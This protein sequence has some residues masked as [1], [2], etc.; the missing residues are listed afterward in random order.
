MRPFLVILLAVLGVGACGPQAPPVLLGPERDRVALTDTEVDAIATILRLEDHRTFE[1]DTF[2]RLA[3]A[4]SPEVRRRA[5]TAAG[6]IGDVAAAPFLTGVLARDPH[7]AVRAD[8]AFALGLLGDTSATVL[9][10]LRQAAPRDWTP[11]RAEEATV[12]V[13]IVGALGRLGTDAARAEVVDVLRRVQRAD[14]PI[15][16]R[17]AAE[18]LLAVWKFSAGAGRTA[19]ALRFVD[20]H[21]PELRWRAALA[22]VRLGDSE[23]TPRLLPLLGDSDPRVRALAARGL[24]APVAD[25]AAIAQP[26]IEALVASLSDP[27]PHVRVNAVRALATF[28][29]RASRDAILD[30]A[31]DADPNVAIAA[32]AALATLG[33]AAGPDLA[34]IVANDALPVAVRAAALAS[35]AT[36]DPD[37]AAPIVTAWARAAHEQRYAAARSLVTLGWPGAREVLESL[38]ADPDRRVAVAATE[39]AAALAAGTDLPATDA[40]Q[41]RDLLLRLARADDHR[42]RT[43]ALRGVAPLLRA[44]DLAPVLAAYERASADPAARAT[45]IAAVRALGGMEATQPGPAA[46][47][48]AR[49]QPHPDRWIRR[50]VADSLGDRWG[51]PPLAAASD[52]PWFYRDIVHRYVVPALGSGRRPEATVRTPHGDIR[53]ELLPEEAPLTVHNFVTLAGEGYYDDGVWHRVVPNFVLQDGAP[54]GDPTGGPGWTIRDEFNRVR[55]GRGIMGMALSGPDTGGSQWFIT[56]S[57]QPHLDGGY[58]VFGRVVAGERAMDRVVQGDAVVTVRVRH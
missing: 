44:G 36:L 23:A 28:G 14:D 1:P 30:R 22:L 50:A 46:A 55:Y 40:A 51:A 17:I 6:R 13:E 52:D 15:A 33:A 12:V 2:Q 54:A 26:V 43:V 29:D 10:A 49:F 56:H 47:F 35:L 38:S 48:F 3:A 7:P 20:H 18:A 42:Q 8:A 19:S 39:A 31:G 27:H 53:I 57:P 58:T 41:L 37:T 34:D 21:D 45:A 16:R 5:A 32:A 9:R 24:T 11:V 25:S 4:S